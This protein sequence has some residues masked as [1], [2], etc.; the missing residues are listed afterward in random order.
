EMTGGFSMPAGPR[1]IRESPITRIPFLSL[2]GI[3]Q[4]P[5]VCLGLACRTIEE[6]KQIALSK[7]DMFG[8]RLSDKVQAQVGLA[9]AEAL[10][11]SAR[12]YWYS[13]VEAAWSAAVDDFSLSLEG[14]AAV[15][16]ASL[17]ADGLKMAAAGLV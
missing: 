4:S 17:V 8:T 9:R 7:Q 14:R 6:F 11:R 16:I 10:V 13:E 15:R 2:F 12:T 3:T 5:A 1:A